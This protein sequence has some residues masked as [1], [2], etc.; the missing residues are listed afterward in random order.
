M[1]A[2]LV[3]ITIVYFLCNLVA[4]PSQA[5]GT[6]YPVAS[7]ISFGVLGANIPAIIRGLVQAKTSGLKFEESS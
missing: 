1:V 7:R 4:R 2:L 6:P 5:T 3:G